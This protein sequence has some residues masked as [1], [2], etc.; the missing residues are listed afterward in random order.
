MNRILVVVA[1]L[2]I[3]GCG[4]GDD[5]RPARLRDM[6][7]NVVYHSLNRLAAQRTGRMPDYSDL[8]VELFSQDALLAGPAAAPLASHSLDTTSCQ[9]P[10]GSCTW[11]FPSV[12]TASVHT[13]L[14]SRIA[15]RRDANPLWVTTTTNAASAAELDGANAIT[16]R[17]AFALSRD[18][19]GVG[20]A[21]LTGLTADELLARGFVFGLVY[22][23][24]SATRDSGEAV[25]GATVTATSGWL[26]IV[27]PTGNFGDTASSTGNQGVF[28]AIPT[29]GETG[30]RQSRFTV[31]PP[32][33]RALT[34]YAPAAPIVPGSVSFLLLFAD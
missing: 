10:N 15:D 30:V 22:E 3:F 19:V 34:W 18:A 21:H 14:L 2:A 29:S 20:I 11:S 32:S 9:G 13:V 25:I 23:P 26:E 24:R 27:Y 28:L 33:G 6:S 8:T 7:G 17:T 5:T 4:E 31:T 16:G 12:D 1:S